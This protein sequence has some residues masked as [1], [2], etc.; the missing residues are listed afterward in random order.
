M[1]QNLL[2]Q[3]IFSAKKVEDQ[4]LFSGAWIRWSALNTTERFLCANIALLPVWWAIGFAHSYL[5]LFTVIGVVFHE[6]RCYGRL[7]LERPNWVVIS[8]FAF[9]AY[10]FIDQFLVYFDAHPSVDLPPD[11]ESYE[12]T[13]N[14]LIKTL[15]EFSFPFLV[16]YIQSNKLRIRLEVLV[17]ALSVSIIQIL[18]FWLVVQFVFPSSFEHPPRSLYGFLKGVPVAQSSAIN[19]GGPSNYLLFIEEGRFRFFFG[20]N[21][22][23]VAWLGFVALLALDIKKRYWSFLLVLACIFLLS[24]TATR[25]IWLTFPTA[26]LVRSFLVSGKARG[27]WLPFALFAVVSFTALSLPPVTNLLLNTSQDTATAIGNF[28]A[29]STDARAQVYKETLEQI[30]DKPFFGYKVEGPDIIKAGGSAGPQLGSHS[31]ILGELLYKRGLIGTGLFMTFWTLLLLWFYDTRSGRPL[32]WFPVLVLISL[33][34]F[35]TG[36]QPTAQMAILMCM[37][38]RKPTIKPSSVRMLPNA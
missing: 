18:V 16:W 4:R 32:S 24:L 5:L 27:P 29:G 17:W 19:G 38:L 33:Q 13:L 23:C 6:L 36:F 3:P 1:T 31:F 35:V 20:H 21:Q 14:Y 10:S 22:A 9:Y 12:L 26:L 7:H 2:K 15:F 37:M 25:S 30:Q 34:W 28:R 8:S 11:F